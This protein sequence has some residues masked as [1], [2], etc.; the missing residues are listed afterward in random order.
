MNHF[1]INSQFN[2]LLILLLV[3]RSIV[4]DLQSSSNRAFKQQ[5]R[6]LAT[7]KRT[8]P[9]C[10]SFLVC[11]AIASSWFRSIVI[12]IPPLFVRGEY[13]VIDC[14][15]ISPRLLQIDPIH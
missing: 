2:A 15:M 9:Y 6:G 12:G 8:V 11:P 7:G 4:V 1:F 14:T 5:L 3:L 13:T 10:L